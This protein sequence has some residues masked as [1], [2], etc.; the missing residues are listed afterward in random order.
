M[1]RGLNQ[2]RL[3]VLKQMYQTSYSE[4]K[5]TLHLDSYNQIRVFEKLKYAVKTVLN[6][7]ITNESIFF[8]LVKLSVHFFK[9]REVIPE[10]SLNNLVTLIFTSI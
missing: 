6:S 7:Q 8:I 3:K 9:K 10:I 4:W 1:L 5:Y 2:K